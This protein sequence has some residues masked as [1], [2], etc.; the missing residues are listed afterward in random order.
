MGPYRRSSTASPHPVN[1]PLHRPSC[2]STPRPLGPP[3]ASPATPS[4]PL[5]FILR[6]AGQLVAS[7]ASETT[8]NTRT[9]S[10]RRSLGI[11]EPRR[12]RRIHGVYARPP[13]RKVALSMLPWMA[14]AP[15]H[16]DLQTTPPLPQRPKKQKLRKTFLTGSVGCWS[17]KRR[18]RRRRRR[19][20]LKTETLALS[21]EPHY[22]P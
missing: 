13:S 15:Q 18:K 17:G 2:L 9:V 7:D 12:W 11:W 1:R 4:A 6:C 3:M 14:L 5:V 19:K 22:I 21:Q 8:R 16:P 10:I 20:K